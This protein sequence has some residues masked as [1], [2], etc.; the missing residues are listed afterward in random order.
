[1]LAGFLIHDSH[2]AVA[3]DRRLAAKLP[4]YLIFHL[5][6]KQSIQ[7]DVTFN[8]L[9][10]CEMA[11]N[12]TTCKTPILANLTTSLKCKR[13]SSRHPLLTTVDLDSSCLP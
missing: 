10:L 6:S 11:F 9:S 4:F 12:F 1:M 3:S 8:M 7:D 2:H 5:A 13:M